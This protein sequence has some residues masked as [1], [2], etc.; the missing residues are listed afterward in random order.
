MERQFRALRAELRYISPYKAD[1]Y[2]PVVG[3]FFSQNAT[4]TQKLPDINLYLHLRIRGFTG[5][6]RA[7][8]VNAMAFSP[9]G[10]GFYHNNFVAPYYPSP[11][12]IIR[13]GFFWSFIN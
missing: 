4:V 10:F 8:N 1:G 7:E 2:S 9:V 6:L 12:L 13:F 3:Q 11:G 5:Y